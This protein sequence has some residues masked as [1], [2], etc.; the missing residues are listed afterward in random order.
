MTDN[1]HK[2]RIL[3]KKIDQQRCNKFYAIYIIFYAIVHF[4][5]LLEWLRVHR[6]VEDCSIS[7]N[8][9]INLNLLH[10]KPTECART[11]RP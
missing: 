7:D 2:W 9:V 11:N 3:H 5:R 10:N 4:F 1:I 8:D 6:T